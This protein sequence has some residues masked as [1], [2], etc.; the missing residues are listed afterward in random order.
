MNKSQ[1]T[2]KIILNNALKIASQSGFSAISIGKLAAETG[3]SKSGLFSHF[4]S[5]EN[6][7]LSIIEEAKQIFL[8]NVI[9]PAQKIENGINRLYA[10]FENWINYLQ[11]EEIVGGCLFY[12][13][14]VEVSLENGI[15]KEK[16]R[17]IM[18]NW[19]KFLKNEVKTAI[20]KKQ[21][22]KQI[23]PEK[24]VFEI[25]S[26]IRGAIWFYTFIE[27]KNAYNLCLTKITEILN[28]IRT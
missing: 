16:L 1:E 27:E 21:I 9:I 17:E 12:K 20:D 3:M 15:L 13:T 2:K 7:L 10:F 24:F 11:N 4:G 28:S 19:I 14:T 8:K 25:I 23:E 26:M 18:N 6:L 5:K 22:Q